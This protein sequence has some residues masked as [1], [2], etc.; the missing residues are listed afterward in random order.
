MPTVLTS[1]HP[2]L[3][4][5]YSGFP[6]EAYA[7]RWPAP[8][9]VQLA[10][11]VRELLTQA[12]LPC[13]SHPA[14]GFDHGVFVPLL[15]AFPQPSVPVTQL[16]LLRSLDARQHLALGRA[17]APL[18]ARE[19][20]LLLASGFSYHNM[21]ALMGAAMTQQPSGPA[22]EAIRKT[23]KSFDDWLHETLTSQALTP[24]QREARLAAWHTAPGGAA[25]CAHRNSRCPDVAPLRPS[26]GTFHRRIDRSFD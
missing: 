8:G 22:V 5:D 11:R 7:L 20:V 2:P 4:Y 13:A 23:S 3:L 24:A 1:P 10:A 18:A 25:A 21:R 6:P 14:R 16:S 17:L 19:N 15:V 12:G 26:E 9:A